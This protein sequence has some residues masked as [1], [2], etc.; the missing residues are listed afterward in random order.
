MQL[1]GMQCQLTSDYA[2]G[3]PEACIFDGFSHLFRNSAGRIIGKLR[4]G[5]AGSCA[6]ISGHLPRNAHTTIVPHLIGPGLLLGS[7]TGIM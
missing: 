2:A 6:G 4:S 5:D 3:V 1:I 7:A